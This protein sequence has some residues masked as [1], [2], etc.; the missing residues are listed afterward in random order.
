SAGWRHGPWRYFTRTLPRL[1]YEQ[2]CRRPE[3]AG[4]A[5]QPE[6]VGGAG[7]GSGTQVLLD[8]NELLAGSGGGYVALGVR[9][10][11]PDHRLL[12]YSVDF[13]GD[14]VYQ[15]RVRDL[16]TGADLAERIEHT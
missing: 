7:P 5:G 3:P 8:E 9:E 15:L 4:G 6:P 16:A 14:E 11:S 10:V 12:A 13:D 1:N 2:F